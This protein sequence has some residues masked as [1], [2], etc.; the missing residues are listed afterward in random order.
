MSSDRQINPKPYIL[1]FYLGAVETVC[2]PGW[3]YI[4]FTIGIQEDTEG[5]AANLARTEESYEANLTR[6]FADPEYQW[7]LRVDDIWL[8]WS[9]DPLN[10]RGLMLIGYFYDQS[11]PPEEWAEEQGDPVENETVIYRIL[12]SPA[13]SSGIVQT[14]RGRFK[15]QAILENH[16]YYLFLVGWQDATRSVTCKTGQVNL[17]FTR[18]RRT[19]SG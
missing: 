16:A 7:S 4:P 11:K 13:G 8:D 17:Q 18:E 14:H 19:A 15:L 9:Q 2:E 1:R 5:L 6:F 3:T 12:K 10:D